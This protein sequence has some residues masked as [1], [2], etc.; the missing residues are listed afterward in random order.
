MDVK[1]RQDW[2]R[3]AKVDQQDRTDVKDS[4]YLRARKYIYGLAYLH[5]IHVHMAVQGV[6]PVFL[7]K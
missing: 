1:E 2:L 4:Q 3:T 7:S 6:A 5:Y